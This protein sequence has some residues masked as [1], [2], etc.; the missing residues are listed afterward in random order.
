MRLALDELLE[1]AL[2]R[3]GRGLARGQI[4]DPDGGARVRRAHPAGWSKKLHAYS[5]SLPNPAQWLG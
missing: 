2:F 3:H 1:Q 5:Q 4:A